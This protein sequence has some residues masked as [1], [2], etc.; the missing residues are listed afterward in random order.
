MDKDEIISVHRNHSG[1]II[2]FRTSQGRFISYRKALLEAQN[3]Q[4]SGVNLIESDEG[5]PLF[6]HEEFDELPSFY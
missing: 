4:I 3:E 6:N 5:Q 1:D 2:S